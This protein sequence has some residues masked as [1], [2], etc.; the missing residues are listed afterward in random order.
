M[1][2]GQYVPLPDVPA[3]EVIVSHALQVSSIFCAE[4]LVRS[5]EDYKLNSSSKPQ[6]LPAN[7]CTDRLSFVSW[8]IQQISSLRN[9]AR[10]RAGAVPRPTAL[11]P[12]TLVQ[13]VRGGC[14]PGDGARD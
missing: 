14:Q 11:P 5:Y 9:A 1:A 13:R 6:W 4:K 10:L 12:G 2:H 3:M 8:P 7:I